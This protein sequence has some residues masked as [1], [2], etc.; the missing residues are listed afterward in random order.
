MDLNPVA[1]DHVSAG[2][3]VIEQDCSAPWPLGD[4]TLDVVFSSN[5][6]EH[7]P[8][9]A[10][11]QATLLEAYRCLK[12]GG[13][14]IALGPNIRYLT[15]RYWDFFDHQ[16][17]LS[18]MSVSEALLMAGYRVE[19]AIP[20]FLPYTM[21]QGLRPPVWS[22]SLY[23]KARFAWRFIGRQFLVIARK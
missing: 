22:V 2:V 11:L 21:S 19:E 23:L 3:G 6:F 4:N 17:C 18:E 12:P 5:F 10:A 1:K 9:K 14:I 15:G 16:L 7:L 13:R 8:T 20:R